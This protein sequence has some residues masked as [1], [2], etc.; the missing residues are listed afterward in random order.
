MPRVSV[1]VDGFFECFCLTA[2][3][4]ST[5]CRTLT[6]L[7]RARACVLLSC[8]R[9]LCDSPTRRFPTHLRQ[10]II[11]HN[12]TSTASP[13]T[14]IEY[15]PPRIDRRVTATELIIVTIIH[16]PSLGATIWIDSFELSTHSAFTPNDDNHLPRQRFGCLLERCRTIICQRVK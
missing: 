2:F 9:W 14:A 15:L 3:T 13:S 5:V 7:V 8:S 11:T 16:S 10:S 12:S 4:V 6:S 1:L